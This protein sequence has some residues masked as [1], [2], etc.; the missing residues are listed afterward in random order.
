MMCVFYS[1][2]WL[3][4]NWIY[5]CSHRR[6]KLSSLSQGPECGSCKMRTPLDCSLEKCQL[7]MIMLIKIDG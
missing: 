3:L 4:V 7:E 6:R 2:E 1:I 5:P